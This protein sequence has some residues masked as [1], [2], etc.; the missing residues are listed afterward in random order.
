MDLSIDLELMRLLL[1]YKI[2]QQRRKHVPIKD[3][4]LGKKGMKGPL[5]R[6]CRPQHLMSGQTLDA[7]NDE[8]EQALLSHPTVPWHRL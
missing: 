6:C 3:P 5:T 2:M 1:Y 4:C 7:F 8:P